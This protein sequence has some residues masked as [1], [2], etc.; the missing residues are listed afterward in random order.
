MSISES[1]V[2]VMRECECNRGSKA[3]LII[4]IPKD[5]SD[6]LRELNLA[7]GSDEP[8]AKLTQFMGVPVRVDYYVLESMVVSIR[9]M[10]E[11]EA[12][13]KRMKETIDEAMSELCKGMLFKGIGAIGV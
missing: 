4:L 3:G 12:S 10:Q 9:D 6:L 7:I 11:I 1:I 5:S 13:I 2:R 8:V